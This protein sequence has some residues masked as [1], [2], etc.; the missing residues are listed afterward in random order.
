MLSK[1]SRQQLYGPFAVARPCIGVTLFNCSGLLA[2][3]QVAL[4]GDPRR[5]NEVKKYQKPKLHPDEQG[6]DPILLMGLVFGLAGLM[7][8]VHGNSCCA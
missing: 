8:K 6:S 5:P 4:P 7:L 2:R 3:C 1:V